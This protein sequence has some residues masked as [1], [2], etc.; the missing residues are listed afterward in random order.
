MLEPNTGDNK[1]ISPKAT[2]KRKMI[3]SLGNPFGR[4]HENPLPDTIKY[5]VELKDGTNDI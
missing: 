3:D 2:F 4:A 5:E 1:N